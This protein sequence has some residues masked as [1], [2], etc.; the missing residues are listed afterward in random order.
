VRSLCPR[1]QRALSMV[2][3]VRFPSR[4][5]TVVLLAAALW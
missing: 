1:A 5:V 2:L 4:V 3:V